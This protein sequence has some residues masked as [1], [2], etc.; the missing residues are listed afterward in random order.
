MVYQWVP[1]HDGSEGYHHMAAPMHPV[2]QPMYPHSVG[3]PWYQPPP[4]YPPNLEHVTEG[5]F[6]PSNRH[7]FN[8]HPG[9]PVVHNNEQQRGGHNRGRA[10]G[11]RASG[12]DQPSVN[13]V[14][15]NRVASVDG[16]D[17]VRGAAEGA[18]E[19]PQSEFDPQQM[20]QALKQLLG[21]EP[22]AQVRPFSDI[23]RSYY[24]YVRMGI[25]ALLLLILILKGSQRAVCAHINVVCEASLCDTLMLCV[26]LPFKE[27]NYQNKC[28][29]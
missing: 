16:Q 15:H 21:A 20:P 17:G 22:L 26:K 10:M 11:R 1:T 6:S 7:N 12:G 5:E 28:D 2:M 8:A 24:V 19:P 29:T 23:R 13:N 18:K 3:W 14:S 9:H 27:N 4:P 25:T